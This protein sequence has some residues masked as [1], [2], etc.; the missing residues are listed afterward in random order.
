MLFTPQNVITDQGI[1]L[2]VGPRSYN[3]HGHSYHRRTHPQQ[4]YSF[5]LS[6]IRPFLLKM[7]LKNWNNRTKLY[8]VPGL[9]GDGYLT[10]KHTLEILNHPSLTV[11]FSNMIF[12][13]DSF[14][15]MGSYQIFF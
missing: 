14:I 13:I 5:C 7:I 4:I 10:M 15:L 11:Q 2:C 3:S 8:H 1:P 12:L 9:L 6:V